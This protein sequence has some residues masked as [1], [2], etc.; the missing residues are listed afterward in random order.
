[1][2][3]CKN[4]DSTDACP[5][6]LKL[7]LDA[8][9]VGHSTL[10]RWSTCDTLVDT[11]Y[12]KT[13]Y[14]DTKSSDD[15]EREIRSNDPTRQWSREHYNHIA[16]LLPSISNVACHCTSFTSR[17]HHLV[18]N[19][20]CTMPAV[21]T[22]GVTVPSALFA[23][24]TSSAVGSC[25]TSTMTPGSLDREAS[26][27]ARFCHTCQPFSSYACLETPRIKVYVWYRDGR[28]HTS[29]TPLPALSSCPR[30]SASMSSS[31]AR[32]STPDP[33]ASTARRLRSPE[34]TGMASSSTGA[35]LIAGVAV[36]MR[37]V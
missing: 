3:L 31:S 33:L 17:R 5:V 15:Y 29:R 8:S 1:M 9:D 7:C 19:V 28:Q 30:N 26:M 32:F 24:S 4:A 13:L 6:P 10:E 2:K 21:L 12:S 11:C 25:G 18:P 16:H 20:V 22:P 36:S 14:G 34:I 37:G 27:A 23:A 35:S